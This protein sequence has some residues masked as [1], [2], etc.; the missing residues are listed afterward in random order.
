MNTDKYG[1]DM[2]DSAF[3]LSNTEC[4]KCGSTEFELKNYDESFHDGDVHCA[5]C[6]QFIR[7]FDAG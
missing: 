1:H 7:R 4:P 2:P 5:D 6:G 3:S